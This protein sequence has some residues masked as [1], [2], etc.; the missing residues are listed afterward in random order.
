MGRTG[1]EGGGPP[2]LSRRELLRGAGLAAAAGATLLPAARAL[3]A[4]APADLRVQ[5]PDAV[6]L[7]LTVNGAP[8]TVAAAPRDT[9][10]DVLR[11]PLD[12][13]GA[14][15]VCDRG[16]CGACTVL[17]DGKPVYACSVLALDVAGRSVT[18]AEGVVGGAGRAVADAFVAKDAMQC[19]FC[20]P[21]ML[22]ACAAAVAEHGPSLTLEQARAATAGNLC[23]CGTYP[24][25]LEAALA[26]AKTAKGR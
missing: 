2:G 13:T 3:A 11:L 21:G 7:T 24:H 25:V 20:T 19:G 17:L 12:L 22:V 10:L 18:T 9:L 5:G 23:R 16:T 6:E 14:K 8:R 26:A 1:H 4:D 15:K